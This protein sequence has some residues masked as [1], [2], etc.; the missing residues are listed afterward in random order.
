[1]GLT[2]VDLFSGLAGFT[3]AGHANG[4]KTMCFVEADARCQKFLSR[5]WP[6]IP[7]YD[8]IRT[9]PLVEYRGVDFVFGGPPCQ[10]VSVA[11]KRRGEADDRWLWGETLRA[12]EII[13]PR[14]A[15]LENPP[16][17]RTMGLDGILASLESFGYTTGTVSL[18]AAAVGAPHRRERYWILARRMA[19]T[20]AASVRE[21]KASQADGAHRTIT[22]WS[23]QGHLADAECKRWNWGRQ[24][25][26]H[27]ED[28][29][30]ECAVDLL[31]AQRA[32][33]DRAV[34]V[35][36]ADG[37]FRRAP[38]DTFSVVAGLQ[39]PLPDLVGPFHRS[40]LAA[41]GNSICWPVAAE[42]ISA[43]IQDEDD[44]WR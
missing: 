23:S 30:Q 10:P 19:D 4:I 38:D 18:P 22:G 17:L 44:P 13:R 41:L 34:W 5:A 6:G 35:P 42:I 7:I 36:C 21:E 14:W 15:L 20:D 3:L 43:M 32:A 12:I 16:A 40:I 8:D 2:A 39:H 31:C 9:F 24:S 27:K 26:R 25:L 29:R 11:G 1:M 33:W 28:T 37:K